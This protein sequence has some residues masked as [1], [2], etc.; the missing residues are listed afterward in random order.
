VKFRYRDRAALSLFV[1]IYSFAIYPTS[2]F[3]SFFPDEARGK[4]LAYFFDS[5]PILESSNNLWPLSIKMGH[6]KLFFQGY[7][8]GHVASEYIGGGGTIRDN[9][10]FYEFCLSGMS[11]SKE[12]DVPV[13]PG[14]GSMANIMNVD[15]DKVGNTSTPSRNFRLQYGRLRR[16]K[17]VASELQGF[18]S[19]ISG[20]PSSIGSV[21]VGPIHHRGICRVGD[22]YNYA[23]YGNSELDSFEK[24]QPSPFSNDAVHK[25]FHPLYIIGGG[26]L[27]CI[28]IVGIFLGI[29]LVVLTRKAFWLLLFFAI[30]GAI[31]IHYGINSL[32][33]G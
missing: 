22:Q 17:N 33:G 21:S 28:G 23:N 15:L 29:V 8:P 1:S 27:C 10:I 25:P 13:Y 14:S 2:I 26:I 20:I 30:C 9:L 16:S 18:V 5:I 19:G 4:I 31:L 11:I 7:Y 6:I 32:Y 24:I 12:R 3:S